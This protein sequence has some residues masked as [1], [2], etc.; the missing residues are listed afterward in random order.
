[1]IL[2]DTLQLIERKNHS[3]MAFK[4]SGFSRLVYQG[5]ELSNVIEA[6]MF[7]D[8]GTVQ[9]LLCD[10]CGYES[11][12]QGGW[13]NV[14]QT[15]K[16]VLWTQDMYEK[17]DETW[18]ADSGSLDVIEQFGALLIPQSTWQ[19]L[20]L[21]VVCPLPKP[22]R[23]DIANAWLLDMPVRIKTDIYKVSAEVK[24]NLVAGSSLTDTVIF[25]SIEKLVS[26]VLESPIAPVMGDF[27]Q[28]SQTDARIELLHFD[29]TYEGIWPALAIVGED[30]TFGFGG[31]WHLRV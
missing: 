14:S 7:S 1:M 2:C 25:S 15:E 17:E 16:Y 12:G 21:W 20:P 22:R 11:C 19:M 5:F 28:A 27:Y 30:I 8:S 10:T 13:V 29:H 24:K 4:G 3:L 18:I 31:G 6:V 26:W 23:I 9:S